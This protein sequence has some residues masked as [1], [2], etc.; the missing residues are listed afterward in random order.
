M[1]NDDTN[2]A[3]KKDVRLVKNDVGLLKSDVRLVKND[4]R[5]VQKDIQ[6]LDKKI[7]DLRLHFDVVAENL[8]HDFKGIFG[9]RLSQHEDRLKRL[10]RHTGL[11][12]A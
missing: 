2:P 4:V 6:R 12:T 8:I 9:D 1:T 5:I 10:E 7:D 3:T 11:V